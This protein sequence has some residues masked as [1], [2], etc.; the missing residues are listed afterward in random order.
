MNHHRR[1]VYIFTGPT[2]ARER[3]RAELDAV[4]LPPV[5]QGDVYQA[6]C[7]S[8]CAIGI[9]DG[10]F[11]HVPAV[12][13]KEILWAMSQGI[14]VFGS[15]SMG[16]L[17]AAELA[18]FG[19][20]GVGRI[21]EAYAGGL[22]ED[23][24]EVAVV[25]SS[26]ELGYQVMS[27]AM[28]NIRFTLQRALADGIISSP[29]T[30]LLLET[31]KALFY[32]ERHYPFILQRAAEREGVSTVELSA[33]RAWLPSG[34]VDMKQEDALAMLRL[35][36]QRLEDHGLE[37]KRVTFVFEHTDVWDHL[38]TQMGSESLFQ[39]GASS[40]GTALLRPV[41]DE[42]RLEGVGR[43][44][45][46]CL[47]SLVRLLLLDE[48]RRRGLAT[49]LITL[50]E[51]VGQFCLERGLAT[52]EDLEHWLAEQGLTGDRA[53]NFLAEEDVLQRV[54]E[55]IGSARIFRM[56]PTYLRSEGSYAAL[57]SRAL[58]KQRTLEAWGIPHPG[59]T[60]AGMATEEQLVHWY[61][62]EVLQ[63]EEPPGG[64]EELAAQLGYDHRTGCVM[65]LLREYCYRTRKGEEM[66]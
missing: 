17:R 58:E 33:L 64:I 63:E 31:A 2:L 59:L 18:P 56:L 36:R 41:L 3:A 49:S 47:G 43:Y 1:D 38:T 14:H 61:F 30:T 32:P 53:E 37:P 42:L 10:Y 52:N 16:A 25:H 35:M 23:D 21:F 48:A 29:T 22:L 62:N 11:E 34:R 44:Q 19:M 26:A 12:W 4:Y 39:E 13:H 54:L 8:P 5:K 50:S 65:M 15:A 27:E 20:E 6:A 40:F 66:L 45:E 24:D 55:E 57:V 7:Q 28:V 60:D 51:T 46:V 9:I